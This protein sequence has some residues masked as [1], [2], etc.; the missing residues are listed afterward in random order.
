MAGCAGSRQ[1]RATVAVRERRR[2]GPQVYVDINR[3]PAC[4]RCVVIGN[5]QTTNIC[6]AIVVRDLEILTRE[7]RVASRGGC[8]GANQLTCGISRRRGSHRERV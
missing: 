8:A 4:G 5:S 6:S 1:E 7:R 2:G 3:A